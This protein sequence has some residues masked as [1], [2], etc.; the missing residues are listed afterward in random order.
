MGDMGADDIRKVLDAIRVS[1]D[2]AKTDDD[3][4]SGIR[5]WM[6]ALEVHCSE[7]TPD[8]SYVFSDYIEPRLTALLNAYSPVT[9]EGAGPLELFL[10]V[11]EDELNIRACFENVLMNQNKSLRAT[12]TETGDSWAESMS[13]RAKWVHVAMKMLEYHIAFLVPTVTT[14]AEGVPT[15]NLWEGDETAIHVAVR[16]SCPE[17]VQVLLDLVKAQHPDP[18]RAELAILSQKSS[19]ETALAIAV[20]QLDLE[21]VR[22]LLRATKA[23]LRISSGRGIYPLHSLV[24]TVA[25]T[26]RKHTDTALKESFLILS[27]IIEADTKAA[28]TSQ[29]HVIS[30]TP[31]YEK[32]EAVPPYTLAVLAEEGMKTVKRTP[33]IRNSPSANDIDKRLPIL[34]RLRVDM[35]T[36]IT[37]E[38]DGASYEQAIAGDLSLQNKITYLDLSDFDSIASGAQEN[39]LERFVK[40]FKPRTQC[41][42][43]SDMLSYVRLPDISKGDPDKTSKAIVELFNNFAQY[44][45]VDKI[46]KLEVKDNPSHPMDDLEIAG[47]VEKFKVE[48]LD[49]AKYNMDLYPLRDV[50][51]DGRTSSLRKLKLYSTGHRGVL[52]HWISE[53]GIFSFEGLKEVQIMVVDP[54]E[55][56]DSP[57]QDSC[58]KLTASL[59]KSMRARIDSLKSDRVGKLSIEMEPGHPHQPKARDT[60]VPE[61][62]SDQFF[63]AFSNA[64][65]YALDKPFVLDYRDDAKLAPFRSR[66]AIIDNGVDIGQKRIASNIRRGRSFVS[67]HQNGWYLPWFTSV[68]VHGTQMASLVVRVDPNCDLYVYRINS[69]PSGSIAVSNAVQ[70]I[71]AAIDDQVDVINLSWSFNKNSESLKDAIENATSK[72]HRALVFCAKSDELYADDVYPADYPTTISVAAATSRGRIGTEG[73]KAPDLLILGENMPAY[74][75][76]YSLVKNEK[77]SKISGSSVATALASGMASLMLML[78]KRDVVLKESWQLLKNKK[79]ILEVFERFKTDKSS[80]VTYVNPAMVFGEPEERLISEMRSVVK[81]QH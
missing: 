25:N 6:K 20:A 53:E 29:C 58:L 26:K 15:G 18:R 73:S 54:Y 5:R 34:Q 78:A 59:R 72:Q 64:Q 39:D 51:T 44:F 49:W 22:A 56:K 36:Y 50:S 16:Q 62:V 79:V 41:F 66:V 68:H 23:F 14:D 17:V 52:Y 37:R 11:M 38:L 70:A 27:E 65:D 63:K 57:A 69:L 46:V 1:W 74:G 76:E 4:E 10:R 7:K 71:E 45:K 60:Y 8:A 55:S 47:I 80:A 75:P 30:P 24:L 31:W 48:E 3:R 12:Q 13:L 19:R 9:K 2:G 42:E 35:K 33:S 67:S 40:N 28:L 21:S 32:V 43:F 77:E 81:A 61:S